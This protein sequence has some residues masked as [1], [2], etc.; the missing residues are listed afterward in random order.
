MSAGTFAIAFP[1][2]VGELVITSFEQSAGTRGDLSILGAHRALLGRL[3]S[4]APA[5]WRRLPREEARLAEREPRSIPSGT[6][7]LPLL[8]EEE[9]VEIMMCF[10]RRATGAVGC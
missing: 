1:D 9:G 10:L 5:R 4:G 2:S 8:S 6:F 3:R 7:D